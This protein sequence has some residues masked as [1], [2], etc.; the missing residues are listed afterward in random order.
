[1]NQKVLEIKNL[2]FGY[3]QEKILKDISLDIYKGDF[4]GLIGANGSGKSTLIQLILNV[5]TPDTGEILWATHL[6][7]ENIGYVPQLS[8][9]SSYD[10]PITVFELVSLSLYGEIKGFRRLKE[11][12]RDRIFDA[13]HQVGMKDY[14]NNLYS[15]LS[16]GQRQ[17]VFIAKALV[18][19]PN[20]LILDEPTNGIDQDSKKNLFQLLHHLN[21][22]HQ[23]TILMITHDLDD[24]KEYLNKIYELKDQQIARLI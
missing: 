7:K 19:H 21:R 11:K 3:G 22:K 2:S 16:G 14:S 9:G 5:Q 12:H 4:I 23:I 18:N 10:F 24:I 17:R 15:Q 8:L 1:M 13:L 20:F 6:K